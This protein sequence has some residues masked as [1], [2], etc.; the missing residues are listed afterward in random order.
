[1]TPK[2][3]EKLVSV[4]AAARIIKHGMT[5]IIGGILSAN[6]SMAIIRQ[7][8]KNGTKDLTVIG[9]A[10]T[11]LEVDLL[12]G[13]G[14]VRVVNTSYLSGENLVGVGPCFRRAVESG[15]VQ[16]WEQSEGGLYAG[17]RAAAVGL[18]FMPIRGGV[19]TSLPDLNP[20]IKVF[21]DPIKGEP[22]LA[23]PA[24]KPDVA[25]IHVQRADVYGNGQHLGAL[26]GDRLMAE[27]SDMVLLT[28]DRI[29]SNEVIRNTMYL[30]SIAYAD[31]VVETPFGSHPFASHGMYAED[32][33]HLQE[34]VAAAEKYRQGDA[35]D[36]KK[37]LHQ[38]VYQPETHEDYLEVIGI[39]KL[40]AL[41]RAYDYFVT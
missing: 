17:L 40:L 38:Y 27:A 15:E 41:Q 36:F 21:P 5:I 13:A 33:E 25:L 37:Y 32:E 35:A 29:V 4:E 3:K 26:H 28:A 10:S 7:V 11:G 24:L 31:Y 34:Y 39:K 2:R 14:C 22:L 18:P 20:E 8:I 12:I 6:H 16:L 23:I 19:G 1:M 9:A 30:T